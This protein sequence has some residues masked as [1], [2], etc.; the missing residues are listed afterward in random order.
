MFPTGEK[1]IQLV[2]EDINYDFSFLMNPGKIIH[3]TNLNIDFYGDL[4]F[5]EHKFK[6]IRIQ[7]VGESDKLQIANVVIDD[8]AITGGTISSDGADNLMITMPID[9]VNSMC[10]FSGTPQKWNCAM[11]TYGDISGNI[12]VDGDKFDITILSDTPMPATDKFLEY[13]K[14]LGTHGHVSFQFSDIGGTYEIGKTDTHVSYNFAKNKTLDFMGTNISFLPDFMK[15]DR[16]D[17]AWRGGMMTF[18]PYDGT[19]QLSQ[20]DN[21]FHL[22]GNSFKAWFPNIDLQS[23]NDSEYAIS[24]FYQDGKISNLTLRLGDHEFVGSASNNSITLHTPV[25]S[26]DA[27]KNQSF[28]DNYAELEFR[29][30][31]PLLVLFNIPANIALSAEKLIYNNN[32]YKNFVYSLKPNAQTFSIMDASRGNMLATIERDKTNYEIFAQLNQFAINGWLLSN[33]MPLNIRDTMI[34]GQIAMA[35]NGQIA[36]D[37]Y[38]NLHGTLDLTFNG[39]TISGFGFDEFYASAENITSLNAKYAL[40]RAL[41]GGETKLKQIQII[42]DYEHGNFITTAP[43][44]ISMRHTNGIGGIAITDGFMTAEFDLTLRGTAPVPATLQLSIMPDGGREYSLSD[45][46]RQ[47]DPGFMRAFVKTHDKF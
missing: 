43:A 1:D 17:F 29:T 20:Y 7:A 31:E 24:G 39:G 25:L 14:K 40:A 6:H 27:F 22:T 30:N 15:S 4:K 46:M 12:S 5:N 42:G 35:T 2:S 45:I 3:K 9:G 21:Y 36:H 8:I 13:V 32:E 37:I 11:F 26:I 44:K 18:T 33:R 19:W 28:I 47:M 16:G 38:Y 34:T 23:I 41:T 10:L